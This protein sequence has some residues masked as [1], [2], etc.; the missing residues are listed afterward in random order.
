MNIVLYKSTAE[1]NR[2]N[3]TNYLS[4][5]ITLSGTF[6]ESAIKYNGTVLFTYSG[7]LNGYNYAYIEEF[8]RYYFITEH[9][10]ERNGV[11]RIDLKTDVLF[12]N[13]TDI[14]NSYGLVARNENVYNARL[15]DDR[16]R[17]LGLKS[18]GTKRFPKEV[19]NGECYIL[20]VNGG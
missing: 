15:I 4:D 16:L 9:T 19:K 18:V 6:R 11:H 20:I 10:I 7:S 3:K 12:S 14:G 1:F 2:V 17:F 8:G 5:A 13:M